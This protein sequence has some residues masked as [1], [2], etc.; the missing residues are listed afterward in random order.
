MLC[1]SEIFGFHFAYAAHELMDGES[2]VPARTHIHCFHCCHPFDGPPVVDEYIY[3]SWSCRKRNLMDQPSYHSQL[4][5]QELP[6]KARQQGGILTDIQPSP[7]RASLR[8]FGGPYTIDEF[9][10]IAADK[11]RSTD[12]A[13]GHMITER[14]VHVLKTAQSDTE[15]FHRVFGTHCQGEGGLAS[16]GAQ[17]PPKV[18]L[19]DKL[20]AEAGVTPAPRNALASLMTKR[21][22][23]AR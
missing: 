2:S 22:P 10:A 18:P 14:M 20:A 9:R 11:T 7:H 23:R 12:I 1:S 15:G 17:H 21:K 4:Q 5:L 13:R 3:C 16:E 19:Y 8:M 6:V